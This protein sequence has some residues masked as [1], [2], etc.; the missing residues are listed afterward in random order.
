MLRITSFFCIF[1]FLILSCGCTL[2]HPPSI[3]MSALSGSRHDSADTKKLISQALLLS[4]R[5]LNYH[6]GSSN[7]RIGGMDCS[8]T[9][10]YLLAKTAHMNAPG[11]ASLLYVWVEKN[12]R[13]HPVNVHHF[14]SPEFNRLKPGDLLFWTGTYYTRRKPPVTHVMLYLGKD[15]HN[16]PLMFGATE[17]TYHG[18]IVRGIGVFD[19][20]LPDRTERAKFVGYGCIPHYTC[21]IRGVA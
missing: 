18:R 6:F 16:R 12:G 20:T 13:L 11:D 4:K 9:I 5:K 19:F 3:P 10:H 21:R 8:G 7:P 15:K 14:N 17:G 2:E 1:I